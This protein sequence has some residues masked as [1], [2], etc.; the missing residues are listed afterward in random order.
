[1]TRLFLPV[2]MLL[3]ATQLMAQ[4]NAATQRLTE[5]SNQFDEQVIQVSDNVCTAVGFSVSNVSMIAG[6]DSVVIVDN[7]TQLLPHR[8][9]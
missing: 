9:S 4:E 1:M 8:R 6:D 5:Q 7:R 2:A 3:L